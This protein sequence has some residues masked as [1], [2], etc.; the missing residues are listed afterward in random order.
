MSDEID[1]LVVGGGVAGLSAAAVFA[2]SG[3]RVLCIDRAPAGAGARDTRTAA[4]FRPAVDLLERAGVWPLL[5]AETARLEVMRLIDAGGRENRPRE[6]GDFDSE[7][8]GLSSFGWNVPNAALRVALEARLAALPS[9]ALR[10][11][12]AIEA[13]TARRDIAI[14]RLSTG[15]S[16]RAKLV[17]GAD[18]RESRVREL[19]EI[20]ARRWGY[21]QKALVFTVSQER[22]HS[23]TSIEI[24]RT[25]GPFTLVPMPDGP[26]PDGAVGP[27]SSVVW[28][29]RAAEADR[30]A[31]LDDAAFDGALNA[32]ALGVFG[33]LHATTPRAAWPIISLLASRL[34]RPRVALIAEAAHVAPPIGAQGLNMSLADIAALLDATAAEDDPGAPAA[35]RRYQRRWPEL[36][37]RVAGIDALNRAAMTGA[38]PLRD[39]RRLGLGALIRA[40]PARRAAMRFGLGGR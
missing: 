5:A 26:G 29:E 7:E 36:A 34:T 28:M 37:V 2:D 19:V 3:R 17:I 12:A 11:G 8:I 21:G 25:G 23:N 6:T 20:G 30:L 27:R 1:I 39:L 35:L 32:R 16:V 10:H 14:A 9:A 4:L 40:R 15:E 22:P 13:L 18:G 31:A 38:Q 33:A 24:H